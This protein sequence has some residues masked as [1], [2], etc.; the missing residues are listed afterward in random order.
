MRYINR[1]QA[2]R[3]EDGLQLIH[4]IF[5]PGAIQ[6]TQ[7]LVE[8]EQAGTRSQA[9]GQGNTLLLSPRKLIDSTLFVPGQPDQLQHLRYASFNLLWGQGLHA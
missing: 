3:P 9:A 8:H 4:E 2:N 6:G 5:A 7:G 1:R